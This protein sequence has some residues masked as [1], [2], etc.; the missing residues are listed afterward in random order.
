ME[1]RHS[2]A[3]S[4][5][6][7]IQ[8]QGRQAQTSADQALMAQQRQFERRPVTALKGSNGGAYIK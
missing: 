3:G 8:P 4:K 7:L 2:G 6:K 1:R 5:A